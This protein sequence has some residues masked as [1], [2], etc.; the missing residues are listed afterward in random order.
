MTRIL[1]DLIART[2]ERERARRVFFSFDYE[3]DIG[4]VNQIRDI[5]GIVATSAAGFSAASLWKDAER[6]GAAEVESLISD[7]LWMTSVT[8]VCIGSRTRSRKYLDYEI[9]RSVERGN[10]L[11][12]IQVNELKDARDRADSVGRTPLTLI[13]AGAPLYR[14][15]N[16]FQLR[17]RIEEAARRAERSRQADMRGVAE[18]GF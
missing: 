14:Y 13:S 17:T 6:A 7:A 16:E 4:R 18:A 11:I 1:K 2:R 8:V 10:G 5:A 12:G 15:L 9:I 3:H